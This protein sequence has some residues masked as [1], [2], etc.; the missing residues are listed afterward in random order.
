MGGGR[1]SRLLLDSSVVI[2]LLRRRP[3]ALER[4]HD[5]QDAGDDVY[6]CA[7]VAAEVTSGLRA[8]ERDAASQLFEA[9]D[10]APLGVGEGRLAGWWKQRFQRKGR[11]LGV[12]DCL[13]A[14][15]TIGIGGR[16]ATGNPKDFPMGGLTVEHWPTGD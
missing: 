15:A 12:D 13:I 8:N 7:I 2:D 1:L 5:T 11:T 16:L 6:V 14:A 4:L 10:V 3:G 9:F